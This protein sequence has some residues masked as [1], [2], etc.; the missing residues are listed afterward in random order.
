MQMDVCKRKG[1]STRGWFKD[2]SK[3][4]LSEPK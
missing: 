1:T 3:D 2:S 4:K